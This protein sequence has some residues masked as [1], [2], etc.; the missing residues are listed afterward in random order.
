LHQ[1]GLMV[2]GAREREDEEKEGKG[3]NTEGNRGTEFTEK[4][5][6][7][8]KIARKELRN[9][10]GTCVPPSEAAK[11]FS[12][13]TLPLKN[14]KYVP[15]QSRHVLIVPVTRKLLR[16]FGRHI[17]N[18]IHV[19]LFSAIGMLFGDQPLRNAFLTQRVLL[20]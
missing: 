8:G 11:K 18:V 17:V 14:L 3:F 19:R 5:K 1:S 15:G 13:Q 16:E 7:S 2:C 12:E 20:L 4:S 9:L 10:R 6:E